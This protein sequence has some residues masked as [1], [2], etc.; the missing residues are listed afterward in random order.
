M[1]NVQS[2]LIKLSGLSL[3]TEKIVI[4]KEII[5]DWKLLYETA[6]EQG[7]AERIF[8]VIEKLPDDIKPDSA[9]FKNWAQVVRRLIFQR[10]IYTQQIYLI[11]ANF[12]K[13]NIPIIMLKGLS[14]A[15]FYEKPE[16]RTMSDLDILVEDKFINKAQRAIESMGYIIDGNEESS[17]LHFA[18][19]KTGS[20]CIELHC[21]LVHS[22]FLGRRQTNNWYQHIWEYRQTI[23]SEGITFSAMSVEDELINQIVHFATHM[24]YFGTQLKHLYDIALIIKV[25]DVD[26]DWD[27]IETT[28]VEIGFY[29]FSKLL[30]D[31]CVRLFQVN[32][33]S[34]MVN[35]RYITSDQFIDDF[36]NYYSVEKTIGDS[37]G[38]LTIVCRFPSF[39]KYPC[40]F[41][42]ACIIEYLAQLKI[43]KI[44]ILFVLRNSRRNIK[45]F[46]KKIR[47]LRNFG[48]N[49]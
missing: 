15:R 35:V 27:Y 28:L 31:V 16:Y 5:L 10:M 25:C 8:P 3:G 18:Y 1:N 47:I 26:L 13:D 39:Y 7:M 24:V 4:N 23:I 14:I 42:L 32:V 2:S 36:L 44:K 22:E 11:L 41:P 21:G 45:I 34:H 37:K 17:P 40:L 9:I 30:F 29:E 48:L 6:V 19:K 12:N 38:W 33:P 49:G 46:S 43:H 20:L